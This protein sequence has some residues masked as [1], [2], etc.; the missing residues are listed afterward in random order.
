MV[1]FIQISPDVRLA[2]AVLSPEWGAQYQPMRAA[3]P[4]ERRQHAEH[5]AGERRSEQMALI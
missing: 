5:R 1:D 2:A 3:V 4:V